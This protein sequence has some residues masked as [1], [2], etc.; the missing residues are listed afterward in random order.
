MNL[1]CTVAELRKRMTRAEFRRWWQFHQ[2]NPIDP[3]GLHI[4][5]AAL[6]AFYTAKYGWAKTSES[7]D[8]VFEAL[9]PPHPDDVAQSV[10]DAFL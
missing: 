10:F 4:R 7:F 3:I 6:G 9:V 1:G 5:P 8:D 2:R